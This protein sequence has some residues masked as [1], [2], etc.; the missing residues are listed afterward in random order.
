MGVRYGRIMDAPSLPPDVAERID[1]LLDLLDEALPDVVSGLHLVGSVALGD[2]QPG[3]S[4]IDLVVVTRH[5]L[6]E[7]DVP[8][9]DEVHRREREA[10]GSGGPI[11]GSYLTTASL[12]TTADALVPSVSHREGV[13]GYGP[14]VEVNPV[15]WRT[16]VRHAIAVRGNPTSDWM[17]DPKDRAVA[18]Y[19]RKNLVDYW[20]PLLS[21]AA[22]VDPATA[23][24]VPASALEWLALGP[25]RLAHTIQTGEI[26]SKSVAGAKMLELVFDE[27]RPSFD[28]ALATRSGAVDP[29]VPIDARHLAVASQAISRTVLEP[30]DAR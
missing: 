8:V 30:L 23:P 15:T 25:I 18:A 24:T 29:Q 22:D 9:I 11:E 3:H 6:G 2:Y 26:I 10:A 19:C 28:A 7:A 20:E 4:D 5:P 16:L 21:A 12:A 17:R 27:E 1:R 13:T 14:D